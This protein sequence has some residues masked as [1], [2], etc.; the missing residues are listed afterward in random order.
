MSRY[1]V[2]GSEGEYQPGSDGRVLKNNLNLTD[3]ADIALAET[4]LLAALYQKIF[5]DFPHELSLQTLFNWHR[6]WLGNLYGWAGQIRTV[7]MAKPDIYFA[8]PLQINRLLEK[9]DGTYLQKFSTLSDMP[10][11]EL[12]AFLAE[13][14]V[15]FILIHP[16]R[17]GNGR[18]ARLLL[19]VMAT[20]AGL[21]PLD[22][23]RWDENKNFY[24]KAIQAGRDGD[25]QYIEQ[26]IQDTIKQQE[27]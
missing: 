1:E 2:K 21:Q 20:K 15:E 13:M 17:E 22:Y 26:L 23:Q 25:Y 4:E 19:D 14:H 24:F 10:D 11:A 7:N 3:P 16:F 12:A 18:I 9:F 5:N 8:T 6:W 27:D